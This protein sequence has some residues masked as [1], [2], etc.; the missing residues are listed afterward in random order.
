MSD[1]YKY[2]IWY[3]KNIYV[4][5]IAHGFQF[6]LEG[7]DVWCATDLTNKKYF[8]LSCSVTL[9]PLKISEVFYNP[10]FEN[11][12]NIDDWKMSVKE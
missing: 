3:G 10:I 1:N 11:D 9:I 6:L 5:C 8:I 2:D 4:S 7:I 12:L